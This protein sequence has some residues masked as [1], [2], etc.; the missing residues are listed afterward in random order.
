MQIEFD[1]LVSAL[2]KLDDNV[3]SGPDQIPSYIFKRYIPSLAKPILLLY[4]KSLKTGIFPSKWKSSFIFPI[5]KLGD[6][7]NVENYR[8]ISILSALAK[9]F[10][11]I[12]TKRLSDFLLLSQQGFI[13]GRSTS[14]NLLLYNDYIF[15]A[16]K[17]KM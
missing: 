9:V 16:F 14:A 7:N 6:K 10:E 5:F 13:K 4:S 15:E 11:S 2:S 12:V 17:G 3:K 1:E 8:P